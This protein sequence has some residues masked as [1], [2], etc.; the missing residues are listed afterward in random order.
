M[1]VKLALKP[2]SKNKFFKLQALFNKV[3]LLKFLIIPLPINM[4]K[5]KNSSV[6]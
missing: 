3:N 4:P 1:E 6:G 2:R 5:H